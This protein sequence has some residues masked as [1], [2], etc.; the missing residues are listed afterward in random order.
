MECNEFYN[1][2]FKI[3]IIGDSNT[4]KT[5][6]LNRYVKRTFNEHYVCTMGVDFLMKTIILNNSLMKLQLWDT[7]GMEKFKHITHSYYRGAH[8]AI[9]CFDLTSRVSFKSLNK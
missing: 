4:G 6:I 9:I 8:A 2:I 5:S 3:I 1:Y 7:A